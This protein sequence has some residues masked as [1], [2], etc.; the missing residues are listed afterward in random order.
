VKISPIFRVTI[1]PD[2]I[3]VT[4]LPF[5]RVTTSPDIIRLKISLDINIFTVKV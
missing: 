4:I 1:S 3:R 2:I 5:F